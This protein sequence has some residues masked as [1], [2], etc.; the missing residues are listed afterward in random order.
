[1]SATINVVCYKYK[2]LANGDSPLMLRISKD[3]KTKY[4]SIG[5]SVNPKYWDF[6]KNRPKANCPNRDYILKIIIDKE[7]EF[8]KK[9]LELKANEKEYTTSTLIETKK[10]V[11]IKSVSEFYDELINDLIQANKT[12]NSRVYK[13]S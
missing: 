11:K 10:K 3:R 12:G 5:V 1:M 8:Q 2:K 9:I 4:K 13:G 7:A 6:D